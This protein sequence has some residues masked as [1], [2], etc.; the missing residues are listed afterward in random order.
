MPG[1]TVKAMNEVGDD[2]R[3][4]SGRP[5]MGGGSYA[6]ARDGCRRASFGQESL[7]RLFGRGRR[8]R[9]RSR[10]DAEVPSI[11]NLDEFRSGTPLHG[12]CLLASA[13]VV[14]LYVWVAR[15]WL[16][17]GDR[18]ALDCFVGI[19]C[20]TVWLVNTLYWLWPSRF[21]WE[22]G[23][24]LHYCN[25]ANLWGAAA[26]WTRRRL[27]QGL[28]YFWALALCVWAF[29]TPT[30]RYG[31]TH[32]DFWVFWLY[33]GF[34]GVALAHVLMVDRFRPTG[35][36][37]RRVLAFTAVYTLFLVAIDWRWGLNYGFVGPTSPTSPTPIDA[38]GPYP[39]RLV[40]I[41]M[42]AASLL[43]LCYLPW[44]WRDRRRA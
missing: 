18:R 27:F 14:V 44:W 21:V 37:L 2:R 24:P 13:G 15:R 9:L 28:V 34:I 3:P 6:P 30:V 5:A 7:S 1:A 35:R 38:L 31:P 20:L 12:L 4:R 33:H 19:G 25:M 8:E 16:R 39:L 26:A 43:T 23:L 10:L 36:D 22:Q 32:P 29:L 40:W 42:L 11:M 17:T 41:V